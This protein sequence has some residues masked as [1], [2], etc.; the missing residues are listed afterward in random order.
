MKSALARVFADFAAGLTAADVPPEVRQA[1]HLHLV[2]TIGVCIAGA[3]PSEESGQAARRLAAKWQAAS[4]AT[5]FGL[6]TQCRSEMTALIN[7]ALAQALEMDDK[8]GSSLARPGSTVLPAALAVAEEDDGT[9]ADVVTAIAVGYEIMIRLGFVAGKRFLARGY[10][11]SSLLGAFG[12][13]ATVGRLRGCTSD[14]IVNAFGIAGSM[15]SGIQES[16]RT[17]ATSKILHGGWGAHSGIIAIDLAIAGITGPESV[18]EGKM[19][20]FETH[21]TPIE[22]TL[23]WVT[24]AAG[25]GTHWYLP[26]TAFKPYPCCQLLHAFIEACKQLLVELARD[27]VS[28]DRIERVNCKLAEP[29]LTLVTE[30][31]ERKWAPRTRHEA[32]FSLPFTIA[33]A[34][35]HGDVGLETFSDARLVDPA[36]RQLASRITAEPDPDS[37]YPAHCPARMGIKIDGGKV[38]S[39]HIPYHPGSA[40]AALSQADVLD[41]FARNTRWLFGDGAHDAG[42]ALIDLPESTPLA[43]LVRDIAARAVGSCVREGV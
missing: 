26:A 8:H 29:G 28:L 35:L 31:R 19:G 5:V 41:K 38:Y 43:A 9:V 22:G 11:T 39:K 27:G 3:A 16:T 2:D 4:G 13:A 37:D 17:G 40:E 18:F 7:G 32:R 30:P 1:G 33:S 36:I 23:N 21:L 25:L 42:V 15:A 12:T 20:F 10:H 34:L 24:P 14:E 6:G